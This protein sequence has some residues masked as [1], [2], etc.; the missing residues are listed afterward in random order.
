VS[1][2]A[3]GAIRGTA[4][5]VYSTSQFSG[6]FV[7]GLLGGWVHARFGETSV[8]LMGAGFILVWL[9][10]ASDMTVPAKAENSSQGR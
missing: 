4:M 9:L 6:A 5:G 2:L 3:P 7:G 1:K 10:L 8:F